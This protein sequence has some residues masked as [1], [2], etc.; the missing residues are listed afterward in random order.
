MGARHVAEGAGEIDGV[1]VEAVV[2]PASA[3]EVAACLKVGAEARVALVARG[4][5]SKLH[6]GNPLDARSA[7][8]LDTTRLA[9]PF[10]L[11]SDEGVAT[12]GAGVRLDALAASAAAAGKSCRLAPL[13]P[14]A[15][16]GGAIAADPIGAEYSL[17]TRAR[18]DLLGIEVVLADGQIARAGGRVV[19][20][21]TGFDLVRLYCGSLGTL[22]VITRAS[23]RLRA[24]P[25]RV[26]VRARSYT[27][28]E[29]AL[30]GAGALR[31]AG[32]EP[33]G[34]VLRPATRG[35][36]L[37]WRLAG[38]EVAVARAAARFAG[39]E[40]PPT[41]WEAVRRAVIGPDAGERAQLR[42]AARPTDSAALCEA[43]AAHGGVL[44]AA[45]P[46]A[47]VVFGE[48]SATAF[49]PLLA[50]AT[51][52][53]WALFLE[54]APLALRR[55][56]DAFGPEPGGLALMRALKRRFDPDGRL[57]PGRFAGRS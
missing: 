37:L 49:E 36:E 25:E 24:L 29:S 38:S 7:L 44:R 57:A 32:V 33:A 28:V 1:P 43:L 2:S 26:T 42:L 19:K 56:V 54:R 50:S 20:N 9:E 46:M 5:G 30:A 22:G 13:H 31:V 4:G 17:D 53:G 21:V 27:D 55:R 8:V 52:A 23:V 18:E 15:T 3:D 10:E 39:D 6:W 47:G 14:G 34:A 16:L 11:Q 12:L 41:E 35:I 45:L 48:V 40:A 51:A